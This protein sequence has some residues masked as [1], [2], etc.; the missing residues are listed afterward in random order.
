M[1]GKRCNY[2]NEFNLYEY[3]CKKTL[4]EKQILDKSAILFRNKTISYKQLD[5]YVARISCLIQHETKDIQASTNVIGVHF[6]PDEFTI[7]TLMAIHRLSCSYLPIDP[8]MPVKVIEHIVQDAKPIGIITNL[9]PESLSFK[10]LIEKLNIKIIQINALTLQEQPEFELNN[11]IYDPS[12]NACIIYTSGSTGLPKGV[13]LSHRTIMNRLSWQWETFNLVEN[14]HRGAFKT[15][16]NFVDHI[17]EIF[18]F[19]LKALPIVIIEEVTV[20]N[21]LQLI[22]TLFDYKISYFVLVPTLLK[23]ILLYAK[24]DNLENKLNGVRVW[25]CSGE[26]LTVNLINLF[27]N[28]NTDS[29]LC[30]FY[31]STEVTADVTYVI[32]ESKDKAHQIIDNSGENVNNVPIG[33]PMSNCDVL[34]INENGEVI[35]EENEIG[36]IYCQGEC[37]ANGYLNLAN[38]NKFM[39]IKGKRS[40]KTGDFGYV[41]NSMIYFTGRVDS[42]LKLNGKKVS[43]NDLTSHASKIAGIDA[44]IPLAYES[45]N[46]LKL[47]TAFYRT[48][49]N[50]LTENEMNELIK[51]EL[52]N[53][54]Y[55]YM[56]PSYLFK[57]DSIPLLYNGKVDKQNLLGKFRTFYETADFQLNENFDSTSQKL[58]KSIS[59]IVGGRHQNDFDLDKCLRHFGIDSLNSIDI[60]L[61][62]SEEIYDLKVVLTFEEFISSKS[63]KEI[64]QLIDKNLKKPNDHQFSSGVSIKLNRTNFKSIPIKNKNVRYSKKILKMVSETYPKKNEITIGFSSE[65]ELFDNCYEMMK[66][67]HSNSYSFLVYDKSRKKCVGGA[68][69]FDSKV[70]ENFSFKKRKL[71][72]SGFDFVVNM[73]SELE[74]PYLHELIQGGKKVLE[75]FMITTHVDLAFNENV[76]VIDYLEEE[77]I[78]LGRENN[79]D[80]IITTNSNKLTKV[81]KTFCYKIA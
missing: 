36:E 29:C 76:A 58:F 20:K 1:N 32:F 45:K 77:I 48:N 51:K 60:Y 50:E 10:D 68:F 54:V 66:L 61:K 53:L 78:R 2:N 8:V 34:L 79:F 59:S 7:P 6:K 37:L 26:A 74:A 24:L 31:G 30:N 43:L 52:K 21:P 33:I 19:I 27:F 4:N 73:L 81:Y 3:F 62:L 47:I 80:A 75:S 23:A 40:F 42:Q 18:A 65:R 70:V 44:F 35:V 49:R 12:S 15:S 9:D 28:T 14:N 57:I 17:A 72:N 39:S 64:I 22:H 63:L 56:M 41:K 25:V 69:V 38:D 13:C 11:P 16:L 67:A 5:E 46:G 55:D 71:D